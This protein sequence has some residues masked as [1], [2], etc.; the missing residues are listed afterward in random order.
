MIAAGKCWKREGW[1]LSIYIKAGDR[2]VTLKARR[3]DPLAITSI[4]EIE[5]KTSID[6]NTTLKDS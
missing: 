2:H 1:I 6:G 5:D 3:I 4:M